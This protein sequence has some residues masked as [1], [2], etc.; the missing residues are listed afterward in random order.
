MFN[1]EHGKIVFQ[2][3]F[4]EVLE[5]NDPELWYKN[6]YSTYECWDYATSN[7]LASLY[8]SNLV[9]DEDETDLMAYL[10]KFEKSHEVDVFSDGFI[11]LLGRM[12]ESEYELGE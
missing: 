11:Y 2:F 8:D 6:G 5:K 3:I 7:A 9:T 12:F 10:I 1:P 4:E